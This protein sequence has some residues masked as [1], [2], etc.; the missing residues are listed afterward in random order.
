MVSI[1][2][3]TPADRDEWIA[4][5]R[6][7]LSFYETALADDVT[8]STFER[9]VAG[10]DMH[11][12]IARDDAGR[13]IG[14]VHW[15]THSATW[16]TTPYCYLEDL[17]VAPQTRGLGAGGSLIEYVRAWAETNGCH[18][19]YWLTHERNTVARA[20]YNRVATQSGFVHY[21]IRF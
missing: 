17:F 8:E 2:P 19:V 21:E 13:A 20:L 1:A 5:W 15:L 3:L 14:I 7:Y 11:G 6:G 10:E 12:A 4:L 16:S 18:K 9:L